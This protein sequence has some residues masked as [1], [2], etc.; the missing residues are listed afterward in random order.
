LAIEGD[1][2]AVFCAVDEEQDAMVEPVTQRLGCVAVRS[3]V[4]DDDLLLIEVWSSGSSVGQ[5]VVPDPSVVFGGES[6]G[7]GFG[8]CA[9]LVDAI[10]RGDSVVVEA[11]WAADEVFATDRHRHVLQALGLPSWSAGWGF[12]YLSEYGEDFAGPG[13]LPLPT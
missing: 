9:G 11:A 8:S 5:W 2:V 1:V 7:P 6:M 10:G 13:L 12:R 4:H 3:T